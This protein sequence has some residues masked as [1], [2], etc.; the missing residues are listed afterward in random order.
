MRYFLTIAPVC[1]LA[2]CS[3]GEEAPKEEA[4]AASMEAGQW[5]TTQEVT[6]FRS[7]DKAT[8]ALKAAVGD[9]SNA[10]ACIEEGAREKPPAEIFAGPGYECDYKDSYIRGGRINASLT[11]EREALEGDIGVQIQGTYTGT[12]FEGTVTATS[13]LPGDGDFVMVSKINGR[14]TA[15][16]CAP[17][18]EGDEAKVKAK[19]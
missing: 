17:Q 8:P 1:L 2:A 13:F 19:A 4:A 5:E 9:K 6:S 18:P 11:C 14:R 10:V 12:S 16:A 3:G 7:A 15:A